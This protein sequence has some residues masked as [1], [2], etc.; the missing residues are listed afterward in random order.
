MTQ[1]KKQTKDTKVALKFRRSDRTA[2]QARYR[3]ENRERA[4]RIDRMLE[5]MRT[6]GDYDCGGDATDV[7]DMLSDIRHWC[8][9][10]KVSFDELDRV[11]HMHYTAEVVQA[12][13]GEEQ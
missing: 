9:A 13:T 8:D 7:Q 1:A 6:Q 4:K 2:E 10:N 11:A 3:K 12:H 5:L